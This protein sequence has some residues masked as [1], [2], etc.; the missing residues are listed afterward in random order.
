MYRVSLYIRYSRRDTLLSAVINAR[1][2]GRYR[3]EIPCPC[4]GRFKRPGHSSHVRMIQIMRRYRALGLTAT[5]VAIDLRHARRFTVHSLC[6]GNLARLQAELCSL[7][8]GMWGL[9]PKNAESLNFGDRTSPIVAMFCCCIGI[10]VRC[11]LYCWLSETRVL[12]CSAIYVTCEK[13]GTKS[14]HEILP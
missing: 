4:A 13:D 1:P 3:F 14:L 8:L 10:P 11:S 5:I 7:K 2:C 9:V 6:Q 12:V